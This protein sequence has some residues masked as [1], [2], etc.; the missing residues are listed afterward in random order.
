MVFTQKNSAIAEWFQAGCLAISIAAVL[1]M[2]TFEEISQ[3]PM[4]ECA[5]VI[6]G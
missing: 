4:M 5:D 2:Y 6:V 3:V 1:N